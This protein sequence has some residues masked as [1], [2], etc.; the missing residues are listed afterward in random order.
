MIDSKAGPYGVLLLR[1]ALGA[2]FIAHACLKL[3][4]FTM[5]GTVQFFESLGLPAWFAW[6][7][8]V[9][10]LGGGAFLV[11]GIYARIIA[12]LLVPTL[13]GAAVL[14]HNKDLS[15]IHI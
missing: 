2:M 15:L 13:V 10:E 8:V 4:V 11:L 9:A 14:V 12:L 5:P 7:T 3:F 6:L 1:V